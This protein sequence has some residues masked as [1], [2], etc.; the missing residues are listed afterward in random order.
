M[1]DFEETENRFVSLLLPSLSL[2]LSRT[3][4]SAVCVC[5]QCVSRAFTV[6]GLRGKRGRKG[7]EAGGGDRGRETVARAPF[8]NPLLLIP[9]FLFRCV[10][11]VVCVCV[12]VCV[13]L[14]PALV[15]CEVAVH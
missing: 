12:C 4:A 10:C 14:A 9:L 8:L 3:S 11:A 5:V 6:S 2:S 13:S 15:S 1:C 7:E